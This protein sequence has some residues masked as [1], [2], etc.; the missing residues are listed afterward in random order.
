MASQEIGNAEGIVF[1]RLGDLSQEIG[2]QIPWSA[3][4]AAVR[5]WLQQYSDALGYRLASATSNGGD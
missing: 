1:G 3:T 4:P 5:D 2:P